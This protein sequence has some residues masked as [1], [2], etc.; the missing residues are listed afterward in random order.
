[1][2]VFCAEE[3]VGT[4]EHTAVLS[5]SRDRGGGILYK[6][7]CMHS[8]TICLRILMYIIISVQ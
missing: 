3:A 7:I 6:R 5:F 4:C 8:V 1:M 2:N